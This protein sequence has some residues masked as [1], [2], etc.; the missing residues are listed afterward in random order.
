MA[1]P[2]EPLVI[3]DYDPEELTLDEIEC[4]VSPTFDLIAFKKFLLD[5]ST[6]TRA[7]VGGIKKK[8]A[9]DVRAQLVEKLN[10]LQAPLS[11]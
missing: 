4:L 11:E 8:E 1:I 7:Q 3:K 5:H 10:A 6:W 9:A 2:I